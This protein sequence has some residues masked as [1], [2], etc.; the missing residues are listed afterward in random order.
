MQNEPLRAKARF[1]RLHFDGGCRDEIVGDG[2]VIEQAWLRYNGTPV[3]HKGPAVAMR[4]EHFEGN[5]NAIIAE[6]MAAFES[7][8]ALMEAIADNH[9]HL[10]PHCRVDHNSHPVLKEFA[11]I[12]QSAQRLRLGPAIKGTSSLSEAA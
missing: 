2:W 5:S 4:I 1:F 11:Q 10:T 8:S 12:Q 7:I 9:I 3:W 6:T